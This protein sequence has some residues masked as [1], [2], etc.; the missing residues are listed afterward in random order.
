MVKH[1]KLTVEFIKKT[2]HE[3]PKH[4][5]KNAQRIHTCGRGLHIFDKK[6]CEV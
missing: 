2:P 4:K 6:F 5:I 3:A 1:S